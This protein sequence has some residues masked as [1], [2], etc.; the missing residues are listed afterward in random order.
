V[1]VVGIEVLQ[2]ASVF[3]SS[4]P[5][6]HHGVPPVAVYKAGASEGPQ[7]YGSDCDWL[8]GRWCTTWTRTRGPDAAGGGGQMQAVHKHPTRTALGG[9]CGRVGAGGSEWERARVPARR[10]LG[11]C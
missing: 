1:V 11:P 2:A 3:L 6:G 4:S 5:E 9:Q 10:E 7:G 8:R